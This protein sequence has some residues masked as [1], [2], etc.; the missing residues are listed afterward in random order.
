MARLMW[1]LYMSCRTS[2][3]WALLL[4]LVI[5]EAYSGRSQSVVVSDPD[6]LYRMF[7]LLTRDFIDNQ[8]QED[9]FLQLQKMQEGML[10]ERLLPHPSQA[11]FDFNLAVGSMLAGM[12][13]RYALN[14]YRRATSISEQV[15]GLNPSGLFTLYSNRAGLHSLMMEYDSSVYFH[16]KAILIARLDSPDAEASASNNLGVFYLNRQQYDSAGVYFAKALELMGNRRQVMGLY[17]AIRDNLA[18]LDVLHGRLAEA[19]STYLYNDSVY[20]QRKLNSKYLGNKIR[21]IEAMQKLGMVGIAAELTMGLKHLKVHGSDVSQRDAT[22]FLRM[23]VDYF[24][25][26]GPADEAGYVLESY[27]HWSDSIQSATA[28][29]LH[30]LNTTLL[31]AQEVS[32]QNAVQVKQLEADKANY[33]LRSAKRL[34]WISI[35]AGLVITLLLVFYFRIRR[36]ELLVEK[37]IAEAELRNKEIESQ[38]MEHELALK[39][40]DLTHVV[41]LNTQVHDANQKIIDRLQSISKSKEDPDLQIRHV[42]HELQ[43]QNLIGE[44]ALAIQGEIENVNAAFYEKLKTKFPH[45]TKAEEELCG[46]LRINM[47]TKDISVLKNVEAASVKMAKNRL[48]KKLGIGSDVDLYGFVKEI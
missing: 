20:T 23:A 9:V 45:L 26:N 4:C 14:F 35:L 1:I 44:R 27:Y 16:R 3:R 12:D 8:N 34:I 37:R 25:Q 40:R 41:L 19:L 42:L 18:Q 7:T 48:R 10:L 32:L 28:A 36:K 22:R 47:S 5:L 13:Y 46:F 21:Q 15:D 24:R 6:R 33:Q 31:R 2:F 39:K 43:S 29:Q 30:F 17:C 38:L 11:T